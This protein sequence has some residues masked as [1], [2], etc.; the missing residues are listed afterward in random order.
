[1]FQ[2]L[3]ITILFAVAGFGFIFLSTTTE[4]AQDAPEVLEDGTQTDTKNAA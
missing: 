2:V 4:E 1:M 3:F